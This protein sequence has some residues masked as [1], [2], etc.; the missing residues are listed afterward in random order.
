MNSHHHDDYHQ[1][2]WKP[3]TPWCFLLIIDSRNFN[4]ER[5]L[6]YD[7]Q[8]AKKNVV[9]QQVF[10]GEWKENQTRN[11]TNKKR[12]PTLIVSVQ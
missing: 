12:H 2:Q 8:P 11:K 7:D 9:N 6:E 3:K 5:A 10:N 4:E 1:C